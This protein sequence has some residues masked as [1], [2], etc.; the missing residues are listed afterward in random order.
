MPGASVHPR[1][2]IVCSIFSSLRLPFCVS[3]SLRSFGKK[4]GCYGRGTAFVSTVQSLFLL[5]FSTCR[6]LHPKA[7]SESP[8][9][10]EVGEGLMG[11]GDG[12]RGWNNMG[13]GS[14]KFCAQQRISS[15]RDTLR[16]TKLRAMRGFLRRCYLGLY[17]NRGEVYILTGDKISSM[18]QSGGLVLG[19]SCD[20]WW[21]DPRDRDCVMEAPRF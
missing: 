4:G 21:F 19:G 12:Q 16:Q 18:L 13:F 17:H 10:G 1:Q 3:R 15:N 7:R 8:V 14:R 2:F 20:V 5:F 9:F 6:R 11:G